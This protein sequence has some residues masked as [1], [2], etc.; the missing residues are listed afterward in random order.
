MPK[1]AYLEDTIAYYTTQMEFS[2]DPAHNTAPI[3]QIMIDRARKDLESLNASA[4]EYSRLGRNYHELSHR[5]GT[6]GIEM[7]EGA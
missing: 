3:C 5:E 7:E 4:A 1:R 6:A 2:P